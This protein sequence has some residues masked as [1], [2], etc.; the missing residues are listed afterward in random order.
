M[1]E[2]SSSKTTIPV[3][4][5]LAALF[6]LIGIVLIG[7]GHLQNKNIVFFVGLIIVLV[8]VLFSIF[9]IIIQG[10]K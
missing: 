6:N 10:V 3:S 4:L 7:Y 1:I 9:R 2:T 8:G 5:I